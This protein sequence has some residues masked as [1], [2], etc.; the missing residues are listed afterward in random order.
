[1][2]ETTHNEAEPE[3]VKQIFATEPKLFGRWSYNI[4]VPDFSLSNYISI[5]TTKS[6]VFIPHTN[7]RYQ[8]KRFKK[9]TCPIIERIVNSLMAHGRNSAKKVMAVR[10][11]KQALEIIH[12]VSGKNPLEVVI[13]AISNA[14]AREDSTRIGTGGVVRRQA[15]DVSPLR[16]VNQAIFL[17]TS[18]A[19]EAAFRN[20]K[21]VSECLCD[22]IIN[23]AEGS[24]NS[25]AIRKR[26]E[27]ERSAKSNR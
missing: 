21:S 18:G 20:I 23:A 11:V 15:V 1:M 12:L 8:T 7:G 22:E 26:D 27:I 13:T 6:Q 5:S 9:A 16:R 25:W 4:Q 14:G 19:R 2:A 24:T 17:I 10:I 3:E